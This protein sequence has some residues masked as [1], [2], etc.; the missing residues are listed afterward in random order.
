MEAKSFKVMKTRKLKEINGG[1]E[2]NTFS[3]YLADYLRNGGGIIENSHL[4]PGMPE[5]AQ[6]PNV[7]L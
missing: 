5:A 4:L 3:D 2:P 6:A 7:K 1:S